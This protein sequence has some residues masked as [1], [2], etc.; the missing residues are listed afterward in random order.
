M[1]APKCASFVAR[2]RNVFGNAEVKVLWVKEGDV[3]LGEKSKD[4]TCNPSA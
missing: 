2:M 3:E 4:E 1:K